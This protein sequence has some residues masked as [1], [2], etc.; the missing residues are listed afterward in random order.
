MLEV[1]ALAIPLGISLSFIAGPVFFMLIETSISKGIR[2]AICLDIGVFLCD[3]FFIFIAFYSSVNWIDQLKDQFWLEI[4]GGL[5]LIIYGSNQAIQKGRISRS[6]FRVKRVNYL[7]LIGKGFFL[8]FINVGIFVFWFAMVFLIH[9][10][11]GSSTLKTTLYFATLIGTCFIIDTIK[12]IL[13]K[14]VRKKLTTRRLIVIK[15]VVGII[16]IAFGIA[17]IARSFL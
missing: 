14:Q 15:Q 16:I 12:I 2:A 8:N 5:I 11:F 10:K 17:L 1:L 6:R 7:Q 4:V 3:I 9:P 13:A